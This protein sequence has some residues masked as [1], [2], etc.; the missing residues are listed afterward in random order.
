MAIFSNQATLNYNGT[1]TNSNIA[2]GEVLETLTATK[3][4]VEDGYVPGGPVT[5]VITLRNTGNAPVNGVT[6]T[7]DLGAYTAASGTVYPL[8]LLAADARLFINGVLQ[9]APTVNVG[10]PLVVSGISIPAGGDALLIYQTQTTPFAPPAAGST[11]VNTAT[12]TG[13]GL[14]TPITVTQ[15]I[16][17]R[18]APELSISK[19]ISPTQVVDNDRVTYTFLIQNFGNE[20][21]DA[22]DNAAVTDI[23]DPIL[24]ALTVT[25]NGTTWTQ[26]NQYTYTEANGSFATVPGQ[27]TVPAAT[28]TQDAVTGAYTIVPGTAT[29]TVTGTI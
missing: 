18:T 16:P 25:F 19:A 7:D 26:G 14:T 10:P 8:S 12:I 23:F 3:I 6:I 27:I 11:I 28:Y 17:A 20:A 15:T 9:P 5:Y 29:L 1:A 24:S 22:T 4:A 2:Y 21:V 13:G